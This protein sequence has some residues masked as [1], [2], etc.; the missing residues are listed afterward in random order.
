MNGQFNKNLLGWSCAVMPCHAQNH[1]TADE[2]LEN[3]KGWNGSN[4]SNLG[5][6]VFPLFV[7]RRDIPY[8]GA[9][10][11]FPDLRG[12]EIFHILGRR[13]IPLIWGAA[14]YSISWG[15]EVFPCRRDIPN[16]GAES[17]SSKSSPPPWLWRV[18]RLWYSSP[19]WS[20]C[21]CL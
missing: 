11:Y 16:P 13:G 5:G 17:S 2:T 21:S 18:P 12:G 6:E 8:P 19:L 10:R 14:R 9:A 1:Y 3:H 15:G 20:G 4:L 7:G